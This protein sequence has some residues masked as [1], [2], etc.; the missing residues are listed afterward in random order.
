M[1][2]AVRCLLALLAADSAAVFESSV[3][4][5]V[6]GDSDNFVRLLAARAH[7]VDCSPN[8]VELF[9]LSSPFSLLF[10]FSCFKALQ[11]SFEIV[12][13]H[14]STFTMFAFRQRFMA[15]PVSLYLVQLG[16]QPHEFVIVG[17]MVVCHLCLCQGRVLV[18]AQESQ[19]TGGIV[20]PS[21]NGITFW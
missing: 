11:D 9:C 20:A 4:S 14:Q 21:A 15:L 6:S 17:L 5:D 2:F 19:C 10:N 12:S 13:A 18:I 16:R 3:L 1:V 7:P 8:F